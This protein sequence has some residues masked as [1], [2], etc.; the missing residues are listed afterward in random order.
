[1]PISRR[2]LAADRLCEDSQGRRDTELLKV[3]ERHDGRGFPYYWLVFRRGA[4][5]VAVETDVAAMAADK[6]SVTPLKIDFTD[7][8]AQARLRAALET[9]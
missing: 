1:M 9:P 8:A 3:E 2:G 4:L 6:I 5:P 7:H